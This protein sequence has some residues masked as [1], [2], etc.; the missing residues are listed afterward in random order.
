MSSKWIS[1]CR[2]SSYFHWMSVLNMGHLSTSL[3]DFSA[4]CLLLF[5]MHW[6]NMTV[7]NL[8][9]VDWEQACF[10]SDP[11]K[12]WMLVYHKLKD[13]GL[14]WIA[15]SLKPPSR[16][17]LPLGFLTYSFWFIGLIQNMYLNA[18]LRKYRDILVTCPIFMETAGKFH[19]PVW[20][21]AFS[22]ISLGMWRS[23]SYWGPCFAFARFRQST[24]CWTQMFLINWCHC[25]RP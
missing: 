8:S 12:L 19:W 15:F 5:N 1:I 13:D 6:R 17:H 25:Y 18:L 14:V 20:T 9:T 22:S 16:V 2:F 3:F 10:E 4:C 23:V 24:W 11:C 21:T 7:L